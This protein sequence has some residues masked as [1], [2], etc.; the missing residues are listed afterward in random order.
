M[1]IIVLQFFHVGAGGEQLHPVQHVLAQQKDDGNKQGD[2][3]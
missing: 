3:D 1:Q 2:S